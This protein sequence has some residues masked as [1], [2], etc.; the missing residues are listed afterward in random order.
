MPPPPVPPEKPRAFV[1]GLRGFTGA[2]LAQELA[3]AGF[4]VFGTV[5]GFEPPETGRIFAVDLA[6]RG[7][8]TECLAEVQPDVVAHLAGI[9]FVGHGD[10]EDLYRVNLLGTRNLLQALVAAGTT[11]RAVLLASSANVY[12]NT[13]V[14]PIHEAVP[15]A[16]ANDYA[17]S[18]LAMEYMAKLWGDRLPILL[19]RPFNYTGVGQSPNFLI[20]KIVAHY[21]RGEREIELGNLHVAREFGD[22]RMVA[23]TYRRLLALAPAG[24]TFNVCTG[25]AHTLMEVLAMM[26]EIAGYAL[27]VRVNPAFVRANEVQRLVGTNAKVLAAIGPSTP[28]PLMETLRW[29]FAT[30]LAPQ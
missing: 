15:P 9:A 12:G 16:P 19:A 2:Y 30:P 17:V 5:H 3:A 26:A 22:V 11:P 23:A 24:E 28:I 4:A 1:T 25:H 14:E 27:T 21:Q 6:D 10:A 20:P 18:K 7:R 8:L 13:T 29:M